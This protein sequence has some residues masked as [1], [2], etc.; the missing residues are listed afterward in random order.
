VNHAQVTNGFVA[1]VITVA[2]DAQAIHHT[3]QTKDPKAACL[4]LSIF[5]KN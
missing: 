5:H 4:S 3:I 2:A 1:H